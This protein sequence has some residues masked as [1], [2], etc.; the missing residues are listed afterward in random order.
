MLHGIAFNRQYQ[1]VVWLLR[2]LFLNWRYTLL[3]CYEWP[4]LFDRYELAEAE[5][6]AS[7]LSPLEDKSAPKEEPVKTPET[8]KQS[9]EKKTDGPGR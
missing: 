9:E 5:E 2:N 3:Y 8:E 1:S 7:K 4:Y 6:V